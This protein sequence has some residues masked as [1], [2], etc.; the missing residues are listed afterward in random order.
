MVLYALDHPNSVFAQIRLP[1]GCDKYERSSIAVFDPK[2]LTL[3][4]V[5]HSTLLRGCLSIPPN[6]YASKVF[7]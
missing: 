3:L 7:G 5:L 1:G 2:H 4:D 6:K